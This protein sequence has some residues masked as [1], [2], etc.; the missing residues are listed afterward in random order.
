MS[1]GQSD[2]KSWYLFPSG[3]IERVIIET[4]GKS[5][6]SYHFASLGNMIIQDAG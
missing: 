6:G 5:G 2:P 1:E 3:R 4:L